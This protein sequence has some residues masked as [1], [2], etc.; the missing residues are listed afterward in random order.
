MK[1]QVT[2]TFINSLSSKICSQKRRPYTAYCGCIDVIEVK[3]KISTLYLYAA[4]V[5]LHQFILVLYRKLPFSESVVC[6]TANGFV[7]CSN[8]CFSTSMR[9]LHVTLLFAGKSR[10]WQHETSSHGPRCPLSISVVLGG[11]YRNR[12]DLNG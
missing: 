6:W 7:H 3:G 4:S 8:N 2:S 10:N 5:R 12:Q 1:L 11:T 9:L